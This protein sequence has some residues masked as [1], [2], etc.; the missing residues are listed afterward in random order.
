MLK[1]VEWTKLTTHQETL[2]SILILYLYGFRGIFVKKFWNHS[3]C[4]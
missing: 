1:V 4:L 2:G 3:I